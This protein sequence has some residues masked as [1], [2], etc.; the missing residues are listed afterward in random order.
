M[1]PRP[2]VARALIPV[3]AVLLLAA[4]P[5]MAHESA[6]SG[7]TLA[8][9]RFDRFGV[10]PIGEGTLTITARASIGEFSRGI[11]R[12]RPVHIPAGA[13]ALTALLAFIVSW[14]CLVG[15]RWSGGSP[16]TSQ[17]VAGPRAPPLQLV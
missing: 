8:G 9:D 5:V 14:R 17:R 12:S 6:Y 13:A 4:A 15:P 1:D 16:S 7:R 11:E 3:A 10:L 2:L